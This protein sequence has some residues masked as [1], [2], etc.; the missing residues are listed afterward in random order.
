M[1]GLRLRVLG[2][3][4]LQAEAQSLAASLGKKTRA[5]LAY[6]AVTRSAQSREHLAQLL[7]PDR[8]EEQARQSLRQSISSLRKALGEQAAALLV[9]EEDRVATAPGLASDLADFERLAAGEGPA[10]WQTAVE[11][12]EGPLLA[13]L[14]SVSEPFDAWLE[15]EDTRLRS[16]AADTLGR[17]LDAPEGTEGRG[18]P[19]LLAERLVALDPYREDAHRTLMRAY[20]GSGRR[21]AALRQYQ[22]CRDSLAQDLQVEPEAETQRLFEE[23]RAAGDSPAASSDALAVPQKGRSDGGLLRRRPLA[24]VLVLLLLVLAGLGGGYAIWGLKVGLGPFDPPPEGLDLTLPTKPSIAVLPFRAV[25]DSQEAAGFAE[26]LTEGVTTALTMVSDMFVI[27]RSAASRFGEEDRDLAAIADRLGVRNVLDGSVQQ[28]G[29]RVRVSARLVEGES[30]KQIWA[31]SFD[32]EITDL[33][34]VQD[35]IIHRILVALQAEMT[36]GEQARI[37]M[38]KQRPNLRAWVLAAQALKHLRLLTRA[39]TLRARALY[40]QA[41]LTDPDYRGAWEG[42]AWTHWVDARFDWGTSR[43]DSLRRA[44]EISQK[45]F[46]I[47]PERGINIALQSMLALM[48]G[49]HALAVRMGEE[50]LRLQPSGADVTALLAYAL[51]YTGDLE[52]SAEL[53][54]RA[55]RLSPFYSDWYRWTLARAYRLQGRLEEALEILTAEA[56]EENRSIALL[57][58]LAA[59]HAAMDETEAAAEVA[60][61]ILSR[62]PDFS[63]AAWLAMPPYADP[64]TAAAELALLVKAGLPE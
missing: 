52:R 14:G 21:S 42:L 20:A 43:E 39:D 12:Y 46:A 57:L 16:L 47:A 30:G 50:A 56:R 6:L 62:N 53:A 19:V 33:F 36:E 40:E 59:V 61:Q 58:E 11:I 37:S 34:E 28:A 63:S 17:L 60:K 2:G 24:A 25:G 3:F 10:D 13:D 29:S 26:G 1:A 4:E 44:E 38:E 7:W 8:F 23:I 35:E 9:T 31:Q 22:I 27:A 5:L 48:R 45:S 41:I 49:E 55:L 32:R 64:A 18:D 15:G 54:R 51:S